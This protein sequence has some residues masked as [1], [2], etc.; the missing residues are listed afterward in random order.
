MAKEILEKVKIIANPEENV[1]E[2]INKH[3][4]IWK[5]PRMLYITH[6]GKLATRAEQ[7]DNA[8]RKRRGH[9]LS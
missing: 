7:G 9:N 6:N 2:T 3:G 5:A 4:K 1:N 8:Y